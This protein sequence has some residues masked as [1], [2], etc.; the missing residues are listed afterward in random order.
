M[1]ARSLHRRNLPPSTPPE[2]LKAASELLRLVENLRSA[3]PQAER[4]TEEV[5]ASAEWAQQLVDALLNRIVRRMPRAGTKTTPA[6]QCPFTGLNRGQ[7][8][9]LLR[10]GKDGK[11]PIRT[12]TLKQEGE[13][14]GARLYYVGSV[15]EHLNRLAE[16]QQ[17]ASENTKNHAKHS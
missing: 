13:A 9:E 4:K 16:V 8:Y 2:S 10:P 1:K 17:L 5:E 7:L 6:E 11:T 14:S 3:G 15:L 12:I